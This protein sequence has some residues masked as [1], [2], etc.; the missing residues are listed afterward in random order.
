MPADDARLGNGDP[1]GIVTDLDCLVEGCQVVDPHWRYLYLNAAAAAH[2]RRPRED[3]MGR[4]MMECFPGIEEAPFFALLRACMDDGR[5][6]TIE[7]L[8]TYPDGATAWFE[9]RM[10]R[11]PEGV[12]ILSIDVSAHKEAA[13]R[14][15]RLNAMLRAVRTINGLSARETDPVALLQGACGILVG[16]RGFTSAAAGLVG[17]DGAA[18]ELVARAGVDADGQLAEF[19]AGHLPD[20]VVE[21]LERRTLVVRE[22]DGGGSPDVRRLALP[23][24]HGN[25]VLGFLAVQLPREL[26]DDLEEQQLLGEV[27]DDLAYALQGLR[28]AIALADREEKLRQAQRLETVGRLAGG[29]AHDFNNILAAQ[30]GVCELLA[31][32]VPT[33]SP[34]AADLATI[35]TCTERAADLTRQLLAFSRRQTLRPET[36]DLNEVLADLK[37]MLDRLI[38]EDIALA[39]VVDG[40]LG[41]IVADRSQLEQV[42]MNLALNARDAMAE[43]GHLT[44]ETANVDLHGAALAAHPGV[45]PGPYVVLSVSDDGC[46]MDAAT[47]ERVFEPFFTTKA[48]GRGTG[49]GLATVYGIV[50]QSGGHIW[51]YS[52][53]GQGT[54][55]KVV[56]PRTD[57]AP[58]AV[59]TSPSIDAGHGQSILLVEDDTSLR[60]LVKRLVI[61][62][63]YRVVAAADGL[64]AR[65]LVDGGLVPDLLLTDVVM[66]GLS[67]PQLAEDLQRRHPSLRVL[68]MSG[69]TANAIVHHGILDSG[70]HLLPKP[71]SREQLAQRLAEV[72]RTP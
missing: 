58:S 61:S 4:T 20:C 50:R 60:D 33:G 68:Y 18:P 36:L 14:L 54:T 15:E 62:L 9:L 27:A 39:M 16:I 37:R 12:F 64:A 55:F 5:P 48:M 26:A 63:G 35:R 24:Q 56:M 21:A 46:G 53:P 38:G 70:M 3:L 19:A 71:F 65:A 44:I 23:L 41:P 11:V 29:I 1:Q 66:P 57:A 28:T 45:E 59:G 17:G 32:Q 22:V 40:D 42:V 30:M 69:Y 6:R 25:L 49:L 13:T 67:G 31:D 72:F 7:N 43:G 10:R 2:A 47:A 51:V 34:L 52:E 8:F